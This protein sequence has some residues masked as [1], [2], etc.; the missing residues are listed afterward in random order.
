M[1][2]NTTATPLADLSITHGPTT[3]TSVTTMS[4]PDVTSTALPVVETT[5]P[6]DASVADRVVPAHTVEILDG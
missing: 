2:A 6:A 4:V 5:V 3:F 1:I